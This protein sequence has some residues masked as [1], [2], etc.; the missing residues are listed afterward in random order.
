MKYH[1]RWTIEA[2]KTFSQNLDYL[3]QDWGNQTIKDFILRVEDV[4]KIVEERP[5]IY[6]IYNSVS[7]IY[8]C[9][10]NKRIILFFK[11]VDDQNIDL[12]TFW[13]TYQNPSKLKL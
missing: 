13:N 3:Q 8:K 12:L 4:L 1:I 11:V 6:P 7:G 2:E 9:I 10:V 5:Q